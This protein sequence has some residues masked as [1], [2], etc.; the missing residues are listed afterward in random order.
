MPIVRALEAEEDALARRL[1]Q[2]ATTGE[3]A[4]G[5]EVALAD[6][7]AFLGFRTER[8]G[9]PGDTDVFAVAPLGQDAYAAVVD[10]KASRQGRVGNAQVNWF[11]LGGTGTSTRPTTSWSSRPGSPAGS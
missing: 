5:F 7:F 6:A 9:G 8:R 1:V 2:A 10:G 3:D 11:A 4:A